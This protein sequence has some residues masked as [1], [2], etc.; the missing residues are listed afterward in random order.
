MDV[1]NLIDI[2][3]RTDDRPEEELSDTGSTAGDQG[4][5]AAPAATV[6]D[7]MAKMNVMMRT[8]ESFS[9]QTVLRLDGQQELIHSVQE[10]ARRSDDT[11]H[12]VNKALKD[13][14]PAKFLKDNVDAWMSLMEKYFRHQKITGE[15]GK[16]LVA[17]QALPV[18][19]LEMAHMEADL[20]SATPYSDLLGTLKRV[21]QKTP[22]QKVRMLRQLPYKPE[23][24]PSE[25]LERSLKL[26]VTSAATYFFEEW[27]R[28]VDKETAKKISD[29]EPPRNDTELR[30][31]AQKLDKIHEESRVQ[32]SAVEVEETA[33]ELEVAAARWNGPKNP[34]G[35]NSYGLCGPHK[36]YGMAATKCY[37]ECILFKK[38]AN[39]KKGGPKNE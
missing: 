3:P 36:K 14:K 8:F 9:Q 21:F 16:Y 38:P 39:K 22:R 13:L 34:A 35:K 1:N 24:K 7:I 6:D 20:L 15:D 33:V 4:Q 18:D 19:V 31:L 2:E 10:Q 5:R 12:P 27:V 23:T 37:P 11:P 17:L 30:A 32:A 28:Q 25:L 29:M 26:R